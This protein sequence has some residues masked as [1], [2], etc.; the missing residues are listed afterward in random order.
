MKEAKLQS[1]I[2]LVDEIKEKIENAHSIVLVNYRGLTVE[3]VTE[4]RK[5]LRENGVDYRVYK[6]TMMRRAFNDLSFEGLDE[7]LVGP[8]AIAF[9]M[10][11][12][13]APAKIISEFA[14]DNEAIEIKA[15]VV[16]GKVI[17]VAG[18]EALAK[19]P[20]REVLIAQVLGG[21]NSPIQGFANVLQGNLRGL[22]TVMNAIKEKKEQE[23]SA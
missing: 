14:K 19:L 3:A 7:Y 10:E 12:A 11:D 5:Q 15:G 6:N 1:K 22:A 8:S 16:D 4:L 18:I 21:L 23:E 13:V 2:G 17:D 9:G 20:P